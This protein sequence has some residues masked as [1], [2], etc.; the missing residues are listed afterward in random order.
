MVITNKADNHAGLDGWTDHKLIKN[1]LDKRVSIRFKYV[2]IIHSN[3]IKKK[4]LFILFV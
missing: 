2:N 1:G 3:L 4:S